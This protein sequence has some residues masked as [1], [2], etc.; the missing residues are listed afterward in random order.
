MH[1]A[2]LLFNIGT[3]IFIL[4]RWN[5]LKRLQDREK[6]RVYDC[7]DRRYFFFMPESIAHQYLDSQIPIQRPT[8][9][10]WVINEQK[11]KIYNRAE[12]CERNAMYSANE[13]VGFRSW[14]YH[15]EIAKHNSVVE[16]LNVLCDLY[17]ESFSFILIGSFYILLGVV[18]I[19]SINWTSCQPARYSG[20]F[21]ISYRCIGHT[22][23]SGRSIGNV[24]CFPFAVSASLSVHRTCPRTEYETWY[25]NDAI[26]GSFRLSAATPADTDKTLMRFYFVY[27][28]YEY[29]T[30]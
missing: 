18:M 11:S 29:F 28:S 24:L 9:W 8:E 6:K 13:P 3:Q 17:Y 22:L 14:V 20:C 7:V 1:R 12:G 16:L 30:W 15:D 5:I 25:V 26:C 27:S 21:K 19:S 23:D 4:L 10:S 2:S